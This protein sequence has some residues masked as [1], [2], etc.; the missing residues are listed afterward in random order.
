M[1]RLPKIRASYYN[2]AQWL[3]RLIHAIQRDNTRPKKWRE[4][5]IA[6]LQKLATEF[7]NAPVPSNENG[8]SL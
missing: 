3:L 8:A 4:A 5:R 7:M 6:E 2:D 1:A